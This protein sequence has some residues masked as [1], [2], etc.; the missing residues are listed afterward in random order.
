M[1]VA[2]IATPDLSYVSG[3]SLSLRY[4]VEALA[5]RGVR[6]TVFCQRAPIGAQP[7]GVRYV[8]L[9][10]PLDYQV[11]TDYAP[12]S[13]DLAACMNHLI[14]AVVDLPDV[15]LVHAV[16]GTFTGVA[17]VLV[18]ALRN[19]PVVISTFGRDVIVGATADDRYRQMMLIA[20]R[21][22]DLVLASDD[23]V[24]SLIARDYIGART[25]VLVLPP[26][27]NLGLVRSIAGN[28]SPGI[29]CCLA[30]GQS[31]ANT[32]ARNTLPAA[33][34]RAEQVIDRSEHAVVR[35]LTV[36]SS[37]NEAKGLP[38]LAEAFA[39]IAAHL[40]QARLVVV[41]HDDTPDAANQ[42]RLDRQIERLAIAGRVDFVG[43]LDHPDVVRLMTGCAV[44]VDPRTINSFSSCVFE[45]MAVGLPVVAS[46]VAC[47]VEALGGGTRGVLTRAGD[48]EDLAN[49]IMNL[50][51]NPDV[52]AEVTA[53]GLAHMALRTRRLD[54]DVIAA[55]LHGHYQQLTET[56][57]ACP[58]PGFGDTT[59]QASQT[60]QAI[61]EAQ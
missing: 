47:N 7:T 56:T 19:V 50:L 27:M 24:A 44:L 13:T 57:T 15:D 40:P 17:A 28:P 34:G 43:H 10:M 25:R 52:A 9:P 4:T 21:Q 53:A 32:S 60:V 59:V 36:H 30:H 3:S 14:A 42:A 49:G 29:S 1:H 20:Y 45:A 2:F 31:P 39:R 22:A 41:G 37:F 18:G 11:I 58:R 5:H 33:W 16:Y 61:R 6:C 38:V 54:C 35:V 48:T 26:G 51:A 12:T 8:E 23:A 55:Q 46:D